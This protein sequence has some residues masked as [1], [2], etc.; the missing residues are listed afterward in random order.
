M[1]R[2]KT[3]TIIVRL[4][5]GDQNGIQSAEIQTTIYEAIAFPRNRFEDLKT[6][7]VDINRPGVYI[8]VGNSV[9]LRKRHASYIGESSRSVTSRIYNHNNPNS[10]E[11]KEFWTHAIVLTS[12]DSKRLHFRTKYIEKELKRI[13]EKNRNWQIIN[14][15]N[16]TFDINELSD[17]DRDFVIDFIEESAVLVR[18]MSYDLFLDLPKISSNEPSN[19]K[20][21]KSPKES[22]MVM[23]TCRGAG[24]V[25]A[26]MLVD[27]KGGF[28]VTKD[29]IARGRM[30][31]GIRPKKRSDR[32]RL[33]RTGVL[34][35]RGDNYIFC[36]DCRFDS[37]SDAASQVKG[38][39]RNGNDEWKL[40]G[41]N[42]TYGEWKRLRDSGKK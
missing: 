41:Q 31:D 9:Q 14:K 19:V 23:F 35:K 30:T 25:H 27:P 34:K 36:S 16:S 7:G 11:Y 40:D 38:S 1:P 2:S 28:I 29:S 3:K 5:D 26:K 24:G 17:S 8:L 22:K 33:I 13:G 4:L 32:E 20:K 15:N 6:T 10:Q 21:A 37:V 12:I 18:A 39:I 42:T